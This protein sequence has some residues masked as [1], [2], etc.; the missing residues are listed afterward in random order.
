MVDKK[1]E[2]TLSLFN[3]QDDPYET[4]DL[5]AQQPERVG[6]M[7]KQLEA[8]VDTVI[9]SANGSDYAP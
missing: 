9:P 1:G 2:V 4:K 3:L 5:S 8:W 6:D 7:K